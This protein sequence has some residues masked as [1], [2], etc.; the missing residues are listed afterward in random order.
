MDPLGLRVIRFASFDRDLRRGGM[1]QSGSG[2]LVRGISPVCCRWLALAGHHSVIAQGIESLGAW[3]V[4][5][6]SAERMVVW[7]GGCRGLRRCCERSAGHFFA[8]A[9]IAAVVICCRGLVKVIISM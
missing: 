1:R 5:R 4:S 6:W 7:F 2:A 3:A 8:F 9:G